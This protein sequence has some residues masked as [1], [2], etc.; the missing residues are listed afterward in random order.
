M[1]VCC[2]SCSMLSSFSTGCWNSSASVRPTTA[3]DMSGAASSTMI[4]ASSVC[5]AVSG[6][7]IVSLSASVAVV[8]Y[9]YDLSD[10]FQETYAF[11]V[12]VCR[13][14]FDGTTSP[15]IYIPV[16]WLSS[17]HLVASSPSR[18]SHQLGHSFYSV[19]ISYPW[20]YV[21]ILR[22]SISVD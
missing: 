5:V 12:C 6:T 14:A 16:Y 21:L 19:P 13:E 18:T 9:L 3:A 4:V 10:S 17:I 8:I 22:D 20:S 1:H 15:V 7:M 11:V 2:C